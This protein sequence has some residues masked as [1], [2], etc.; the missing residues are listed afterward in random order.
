MHGSSSGAARSC[1]AH[2]QPACG[3]DEGR[4]FGVAGRRGDQKE[5]VK[6]GV[7]KINIDTDIRLVSDWPAVRQDS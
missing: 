5:A 3:N 6:H 2:H 4:T 1:L 7:R